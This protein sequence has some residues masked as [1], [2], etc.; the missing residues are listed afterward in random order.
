MYA[1]LEYT[2]MLLFQS[3][4]TCHGTNLYCAVEDVTLDC[5]CRF[6]GLT[7]EDM[8]LYQTIKQSGT[9]GIWTRDMKFK[10][11]LQQPQITKIIKTLEG[12]K[13]IKAVKSVAVSRV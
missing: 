1:V 10:T 2:D 12:R 3:T 4:I 6:K 11:N 9:K 8:L 13:L 7:P 5:C